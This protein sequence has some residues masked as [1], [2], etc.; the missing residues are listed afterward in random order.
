MKSFPKFAPL[1]GVVT[2]ILLLL[3]TN[4]NVLAQAPQERNI[5]QRRGE[6]NQ[7]QLQRREQ[8]DRAQQLRNLISANQLVGKEV[9]N[10][11]DETVGVVQE[12][13]LDTRRNQIRY[14]VLSFSSSL[15]FGDRSYT[16]PW[17]DFQIVDSRT[18]Q[19]QLNVDNETIRESQV[20]PARGQEDAATYYQTERSREQRRDEAD[21]ETARGRRPGETQERPPLHARWF[22]AYRAEQLDE[23]VE[24]KELTDEPARRAERRDRRTE[25]YREGE[26]ESY[27]AGRERS[28]LGPIRE[29][30]EE[31]YPVWTRGVTDIVGANVR[32]RD[33]EDVGNLEDVV[34]DPQT[35]AIA[36]AVVSASPLDLQND[37]VAIPWDLVNVSRDR[38]Q[39]QIDT[40]VLTLN[41]VSMSGDEYLSKL[42]DE[43][44]VQNLHDTFGTEPYWQ[45]YGYVGELPPSARIWT[46]DSNY[47]RKFL[48]QK[49]ETVSGTIQSVGTFRPNPQA[50]PGRRLRI[51]T[52]TGTTLTIHTGP[53][54][55]LRQKG[56]T[57]RSGDEI[58]VT[59]SKAN[60]NGRAVVIASEVRKGN[61]QIELRDRAGKPEWRA[62][63]L[64]E[65]S[66]NNRFRTR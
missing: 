61:Q 1:S 33:G 12:V 38:S 40:N 21:R 46:G 16:I 47:N 10:Q 31:Q 29:Y 26:P 42:Q 2:G 66:R 44:F 7:A 37:T 5:Q 13:I 65:E 41:Q 20:G 55:F 36:Y 32:T 56:I 63:N 22:G 43:E 60:V 18:A 64:R 8:D 3:L 34:L 51:R 9:V 15:G 11:N 14:A 28:R 25:D 24:L 17:T 6:P 52:E 19:L 48:P 23:D 59:G 53:T 30:N 35:G 45:T 49:I 27:Q 39:I 57:F 4:I 58:T 50:V 54:P 62:E